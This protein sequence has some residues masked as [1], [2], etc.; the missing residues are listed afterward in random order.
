M[1]V[2]A[3]GDNSSFQSLLESVGV[4]SGTR[5]ALGQLR[6]QLMGRWGAAKKAEIKKVGLVAASGTDRED[7]QNLLSQLREYGLFFVPSGEL[8]SWLPSLARGYWATKP[9]WL[10]ATFTAMGEDAS[11][12]DYLVPSSGDVWDF[13]RSIK[14]WLHN[15]QR[16]GMTVSS[17]I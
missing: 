16:K 14:D 15:P 4:T 5:L 9:E 13:L 8:E 10:T 2:V 12:P 7:L 17:A 1:D 11:A 6:G 3:K